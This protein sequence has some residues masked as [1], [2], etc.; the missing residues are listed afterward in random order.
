MVILEAKVTQI[1]SMNVLRLI[2]DFIKMSKVWS[3]SME[4][5]G[6]WQEV[7]RAISIQRNM[8]T[9]TTVCMNDQ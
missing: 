2:T 4:F 9:L 8:V 6:V 5:Y 7:A 1:Y 3:L